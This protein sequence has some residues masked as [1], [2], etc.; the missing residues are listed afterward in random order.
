MAPVTS[1]TNSSA[2]SGTRVRRMRDAV[3]RSGTG[4]SCRLASALSIAAK[5]FWTMALPFFA[6]VRSVA[7]LIASIA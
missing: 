6:Y 5:F 1:R 4:T 3:A 2:D 7:R